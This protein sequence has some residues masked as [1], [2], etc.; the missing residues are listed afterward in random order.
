MNISRLLKSTLVKLRKSTYKYNGIKLNAE[1]ANSFIS[2]LLVDESYGMIT[3]IGSVELECINEYLNK[4]KFTE[5]TMKKMRI[6]A[7]FFPT[8]EEKLVQFC[9]LYIDCLGDAD[10]IGIWY[11]KGE[12]KVINKFGRSARLCE[13][14]YLEPYYHLEPWSQYLKDKK[15]LVIHPFVETITYQYNN[16]REKLFKQKNLLPKFDLYT[17]KAVQSISG[18]TEGYKDWFEAL[19]YMKNKIDSYNYDIAIIGAGAYGLPLASYIKR[20]GKIAIHL[21]GATQ[22]LFGIKGKRWDSHP[23][24]SNLYN[25]Y[26]TRPKESEKPKNYNQVEGGCYW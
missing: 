5:S 16:N 15:V 6:N 18:N 23:F 11:N 3:R 25:D 17:L 24:I 26:W 2:K 10:L 14:K 22:V 20:K 7:G 8:E 13:L 12:N 4:R 19:D 1:E 9:E 21:G